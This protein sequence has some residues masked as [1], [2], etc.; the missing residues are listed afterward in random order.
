MQYEELYECLVDLKF[1]PNFES[2]GTTVRKSLLE[3][4]SPTS[5][6][7]GVALYYR[8]NT[9][10]TKMLP[11]SYVAPVGFRLGLG[12]RLGLRLWLRVRAGP[13]SVQGPS[14]RV[15]VRVRVRVRGRGWA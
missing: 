14:W 8:A 3:V 10:L 9:T 2:T 13:R 6:L 15:R 11:A 7:T 12:P 4:N 1:C 5:S